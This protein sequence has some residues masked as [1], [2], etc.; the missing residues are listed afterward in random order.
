MVSG[1]FGTDAWALGVDTDASEVRVRC[2]NARTAHGGAELA[3]E[4]TSISPAFLALESGIELEI[5]ITVLRGGSGS[6]FRG[7]VSINPPSRTMAEARQ[8]IGAV[9]SATAPNENFG[10]ESM[11]GLT[12]TLR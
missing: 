3:N 5:V 6:L 10:C 9:A 7:L 4:R 2:Y 12:A 8:M 11:P 1:Q